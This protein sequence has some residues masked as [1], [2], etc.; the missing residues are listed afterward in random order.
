MKISYNWLKNYIE[1]PHTPEELSKTLTMCGLEVEQLEEIGG[2]DFSFTNVVVGFVEKVIKHPEADRLRICTVNV[3]QETPLTIVCGAPN[4]AEGQKV[5]V[6]MIGAVLHPT[7]STEPLKIKKGKIRGQESQGM[8]CAEDELGMGKSHEGILVLDENTEIGIPLEKALSTNLDYQLE[9]AITPN[10]VD[11]TSH[12]GVARDIAAI[13]RKPLTFPEILDKNTLSSPNPISIEI[14][15]NEKCQKYVAIHIQGVSVGESPEWLKERLIAVGLRPINNIVD[16]TN[17]VMMEVGQPLH[18]FD[19]DTLSGNKIV[20]RTATEGEKF[21]TLDGKEHTLSAEDLMICDAES[22]KCIAGVFGGLNSGVTENTKNILLESA[23]FDATSV[24]KTSKRLGIKTDSSFRFERGANPDIQEWA[25]LR[26]TKFILECAGGTASVVTEVKTADFEPFAIDLSVHKTQTMIGKKIPKSEIVE[27]LQYLDIA[28]EENEDGN[29][30]HLKV[31][32]Y[33]VDVQRP[34]DVM[35]E[36]LRIYGF[37]NVEI[38]AQMWFTPAHNKEDAFVLRQKLADALSASGLYEMWNNSL[39]SIKH[40][41]ENAVKI[42]NPLSEELGVM[43]ESLLWGG[44]EVIRFNQNRQNENLALYEFGKIYWSEG[45]SESGK[46]KYKEQEQFAVFITGNKAE[47]HWQTKTTKSSLYSLTKIVEQIANL[48]GI[49]GETQETEH[50]EMAYAVQYVAQKQ[51]V[52]KWG[53]VKPE[54]QEMFDI[55]NEVFY[56]V[57]DWAKLTKLYFQSSVEYKPIAAYPGISR[58]ISLFIDDSVTFE[59]LKKAVMQVNPNLIKSVE[60]L[61][62]YKGKNMEEGKKSYLISMFLQDNERTLEDSVADKTWEKVC[63][64]L[65]NRV[66]AVIRK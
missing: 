14:A 9:V 15:N 28:V 36:I 6:A 52:M 44:L 65:E 23:Y 53:M 24:R 48:L 40:S 31:P 1:F 66:G 7:D 27:I 46:P 30:L 57:L 29:L 16:I 26:A 34:Q 51:A 11:A 56:L 54:Y 37:N 4:V 13:S 8:I 55:R 22:P 45:I 42:L 19:A 3:G 47:Q 60:L 21:V 5:P 38:P 20:V 17:F 18:A 59:S 63:K 61:D 10:R 2:G 62:V 12:I 49:K 58:D 35:E 39:T 33:R 43:R 25:A 64:T 41:T 32:Q 50:S